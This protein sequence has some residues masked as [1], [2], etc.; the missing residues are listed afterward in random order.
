[1]T[2]DLGPEPTHVWAL[3]LGMAGPPG[4]ATMHR[5]REP[6]TEWYRHKSAACGRHLTWPAS[7]VG[8]TEHVARKW[9]SSAVKVCS[10]CWPEGIA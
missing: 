1:M 4:T 9:L 10:K 5:V 7:S 8:P 2:H 3:N 6:T